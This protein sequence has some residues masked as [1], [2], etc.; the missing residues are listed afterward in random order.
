MAQGVDV[1]TL[2]FAEVVDLLEHRVELVNCIYPI[3][4]SAGLAPAG[5][6]DRRAERI[7][8][9]IVALDEIEFELYRHHWDPVLLFKKTEHSFQ[10]M[11]C[12]KRNGSSVEI[13]GVA[14]DLSSWIR[15]PG[16]QADS[17]GIRF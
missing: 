17:I 8:R 9:I 5:A 12:R 4:L 15:I 6:A 11:T 3:G 7:V 10:H 13:I 16:H 2:G 14:D 1:D